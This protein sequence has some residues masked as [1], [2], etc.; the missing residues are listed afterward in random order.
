[1]TQFCLKFPL[2]KFGSESCLSPGWIKVEIVQLYVDSK[3][4]L[5]AYINLTSYFSLDLFEASAVVQVGPIMEVSILRD[6]VTGVS[7]GCAFVIYDD[8]A[9]AE[10][11]IARIDRHF[12]LPGATQPIEVRS[13]GPFHVIIL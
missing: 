12:T 9:V 13:P 7:R 2:Y 3:L 10:A 4:I 11:A 1:M 8:K 6:Q 5:S